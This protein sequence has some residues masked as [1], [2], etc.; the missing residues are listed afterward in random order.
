MT[1]KEWQQAT[2]PRPLMEYLR[3]KRSASRTKSGKRKLRLFA[4]ACL[5]GIWSLL[6]QPGSR[7]ALYYAEL[8][9]DG[10][11]TDNDLA[12]AHRAARIARRKEA[13]EFGSSPYWQS[14]EAACHVCEKR[15]DNGDHTSVAHASFSSATAWAIDRVRSGL[16]LTHGE[17]SQTR[18]AVHADWLRDIFGNPFR[19]VA[20]APEWRTDTAIALA[21]TMYESREFSAMPIL[22]D[23][24]QDAGCDNDDVLNHCRGAGPHVRGC[25]VCDL[26]LGLV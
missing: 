11:T 21:R 26:V 10:E 6:R 3:A 7:Q 1:E 14:A 8:Y 9:A 24:L 16:G 23:A 19:P 15:F 13:G 2:D 25:W 17:E 5:H 20:F 4:C 18:H 12:T 22:A